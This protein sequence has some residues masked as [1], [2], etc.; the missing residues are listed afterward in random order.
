MFSMAP[1][2]SPALNPPFPSRSTPSPFLA[3][4]PVRLPFD[5]T[6]MEAVKGSKVPTKAPSPSTTTPPPLTITQ[7]A[8]RIDLALKAGIPD[9]LRFTGEISGF[10]HRTHWYFDLKDAAAVVNCVMFQSG[11]RKAGFTPANGQQV[12]ATGRIE[13]YAPGGKVSVIIEK[14]EPVG[15]G[16]LE[17][18]YRALCEELRALGWFAPERKRP[19]PTFPRR[20][21]I[22]T[23][24]TGAALQDVLVTMKKRCPAVSVLIVD[25]RVQGASAA[26]EVAAAITDLSKRA[27]ELKIDAILVTRG[28]GSMEDLWA[29]NDRIVAQAIVGSSIPVVAAI[30]HETDT[31]IAEL[32]ADERCATPTQAAMRLTPD[33]AALL[34]QIDSTSSRLALLLNRRLTSSRKAIE[35]LASRPLFASPKAALAATASKLTFFTSR[36][37]SG[38]S[39]RMSRHRAS[40]NT[41]SIRLE[42]NRPAALHAKRQARL[43][44]ASARLYALA[45]RLTQSPALDAR[46]QRLNLA[47]RAAIRTNSQSLDSL[48]RE[49]AA[50]APQ[51][52]LERGFSLTTDASGRVI[53]AANQASPGDTITT[54]LADGQLQSVVQVDQNSTT[55]NSPPATPKSTPLARPPRQKPPSTKSTTQP[56]PTPGLFG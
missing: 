43:W 15:A 27:N 36:L 22:V 7:V 34:R 6:K 44:T 12:I 52:V 23:S 20:I 2:S 50:V 31:T 46:V 38:I 9:S 16:S 28:G 56:P 40:L 53:R 29:F 37:S 3:L 41:L 1:A 51:R 39:A 18:A 21:A 13:F 32:V 49:L 42:R 55:S 48:Q 47:I 45:P 17:L 33:S 14:L 35:A 5:P 11:A 30:G 26:P 4:L 10:R 54:K 25:C 19:L 24:R 8:S